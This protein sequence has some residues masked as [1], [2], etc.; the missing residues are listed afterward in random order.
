M[1][2]LRAVF[3]LLTDMAFDTARLDTLERS[4]ENLRG[5]GLD[6]ANRACVGIEDEIETEFRRLG[7]M[8]NFKVEKVGHEVESEAA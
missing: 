7:K 8:L 4:R 6:L 3:G 2:N 5:I 1:K